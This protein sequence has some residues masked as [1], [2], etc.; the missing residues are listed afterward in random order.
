MELIDRKVA[1]YIKVY[2][3]L[4]YVKNPFKKWVFLVCI[5]IALVLTSGCIMSESATFVEKMTLIVDPQTPQF[6]NW[7]NYVPMPAVNAGCE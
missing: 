2:F 1:R 6:N 4:Y 7:D 5:M 3:N